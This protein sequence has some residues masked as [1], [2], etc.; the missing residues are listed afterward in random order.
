MKLRKMFYSEKDATGQTFKKQSAKWYA[1][2]SAHAAEVRRLPLDE[3]KESANEYAGKIAKLHKIRAT[4]DVMP[5]ELADFVKTCPPL[6][7]NKLVEWDV[8]QAVKVFADAPLS[9]H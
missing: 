6:I 8:I 4:G 5:V 2:G 1:V 9:E 7:G 3:C